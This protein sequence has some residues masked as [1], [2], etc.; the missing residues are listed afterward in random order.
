MAENLDSLCTSPGLSARSHTKHDLK[1]ILQN[2]A[3]FGVVRIL[4]TI[5]RRER[6][7]A[8]RVYANEALRKL[9]GLPEVKHV[10]PLVIKW[11]LREYE[12]ISTA[13]SAATTTPDSSTPQA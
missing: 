6:R 10:N 13:E 2:I 9:K 5:P 7:R 12:K 3:E 4:G 8:G 1:K 11:I